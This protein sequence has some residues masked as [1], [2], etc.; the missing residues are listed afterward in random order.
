MR[1][2]LDIAEPVLND[3]K[4]LQQREG[5]SLGRLASDRLAQALAAQRKRES[6]REAF[7]WVTRK[8]HVRADLAD[9]DALLDSIDGAR[10]G[11]R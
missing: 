2:T 3:L 4:R 10:D 11:S 6:Q 9:R 1:T 5:K 7:V 8:M